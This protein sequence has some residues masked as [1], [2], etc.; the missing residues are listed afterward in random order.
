[1]HKG[2]VVF[3]DRLAD[4]TVFRVYGEKQ[5]CPSGCF[6]LYATGV[7]TGGRGGWIPQLGGT[8]PTATVFQV[9]PADSLR[10]TEQVLRELKRRDIYAYSDVLFLMACSRNTVAALRDKLRQENPGLSL[11]YCPRTFGAASITNHASEQE[12]LQTPE[13]H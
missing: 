2:S 6:Y 10:I 11:L 8:A 7:L 5:D 3:E 4:I 12:Q 1:M 9:Q 13:Y